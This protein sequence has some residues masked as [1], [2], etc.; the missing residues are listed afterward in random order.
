[1]SSEFNNVKQRFLPIN[2]SALQGL[3]HET[4]ITDFLIINE[5]GEHENN[6]LYH[7]YLIK[8]KE[9]QVEYIIKAF[10]KRQLPHYA[11]SPYFK[12]GIEIIYN[13]NHPNISKY[14]GHFEDNLYCYFIMEYN[15]R[16][17]LY[18]LWPKD[19]KKKI[20]QKVCAS[21]IKDII[22]GIYFLHNMKPPI[23]HR[24][25]KP[26][27]I[28]ITKDLIAKINDYAWKSYIINNKYSYYKFESPI[29]YPPEK[30]YDGIYN[31]KGDIWC[32]GVLLFE[33]LTLNI[34]FQGNDID[35]LKDN[36]R[37]VKIQWPKDINN[38]AK[39]LIKKILKKNPNERIS[40]EEMIKHPFITKYYPDAEKCLIKPE[41]GVKYKPFII[42]KDE[43]KTWKSEKI[44]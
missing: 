8:H 34:P 1:M 27:N 24:N 38:E 36:I 43:P 15:N 22:S 12:K 32:I 29:Y 42:C 19:K 7:V 17:N 20:S 26:E 41:E 10:D 16:G 39:D 11:E 13:I 31:E 18:N 9:T 4:R 2:E 6:C 37:N 3:E 30:I 28:F 25:I 21:I 40:L 14:F 44:V 33:L 23:I 35:T 5:R